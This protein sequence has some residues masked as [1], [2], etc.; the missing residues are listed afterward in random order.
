MSL[1][2]GNRL[3]DR[4]MKYLQVGRLVVLATVDE[5][6]RPDTCPVS[7]VV[8][9]NPSVIRLAISREVNTYHN[10]LNNEHV[11]ISLVGGAMTLGIRGRARALAESLDGI[12]LSMAL[13]EMEVDEVKDDSVIGRGLQDE[14]VKWEERRRSVSDWHVENALK[15]T[16]PLPQTDTSI[17]DQMAQ[18]YDLA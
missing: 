14:L 6:G 17:M 18:N 7:W 3:P 2:L 8:A 4:A 12:P 15:T 13:I 9:L 10:I 11:M 1:I 5:Q 16:G